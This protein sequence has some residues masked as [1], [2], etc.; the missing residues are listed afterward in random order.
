MPFDEDAE[1]DERREDAIRSA[2]AAAEPPSLVDERD[3]AL[4]DASGKDPAAAKQSKRKG[5]KMVIALF[6]ALS[7]FVILG[8]GAYVVI[9]LVAGKKSEPTLKVGGGEERTVGA[10]SAPNND[11]KLEAALNVLASRDTKAA[12]ANGANAVVTDP[13]AVDQSGLG[14]SN[15]NLGPNGQTGAGEGAGLRSETVG[16]ERGSGGPFFGGDTSGGGGAR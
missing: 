13:G 6:L 14:A 10:P 11:E 5:K 7:F 8:V 3:A 9:R 12:G 15:T 4:L 1:G 2:A 16:G